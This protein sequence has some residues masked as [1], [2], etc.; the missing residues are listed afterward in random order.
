MSYLLDV[1]ALLAAIWTVHPHCAST[2]AWLK[3]KNVAIC[4]LVELGFLRI[5]TNAKAPFNVSMADARKALEKFLSET[6]AARIADDL[7]ALDS[8]PTRSE[9]VTDQYLADLAHKHGLRLA[10]LDAGIKHP[11]IE[12]I[13]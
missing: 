4:P 8:H 2:D 13:R 5:S 3:G 1:N 6:K 12:L 11:A 10:T 9:A 7:P